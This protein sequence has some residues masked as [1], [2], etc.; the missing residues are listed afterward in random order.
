M[1]RVA[2]SKRRTTTSSTPRDART[3]E[4]RRI[5]DQ[6]RK[7]LQTDVHITVGADDRGE[8]KIPFYSADDLERLLDLMLG[9]TRETL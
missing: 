6:L 2:G 3:A 8:V 5:E 9:A 4:A 1:T 7:H